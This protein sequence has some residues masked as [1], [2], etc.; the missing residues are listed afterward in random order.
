MI[1]RPPSPP[2]APL[3]PLVLPRPVVLVRPAVDLDL[4]LLTGLED[5]DIAH[6]PIEHIRTQQLQ[7]PALGPQLVVLGAQRVGGPPVELDLALGAGL[8]DGSVERCLGHGQRI[9][10]YHFCSELFGVPKILVLKSCPLHY[11]AARGHRRVVVAKVP[12]QTVS[13][14]MLQGSR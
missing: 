8:P 9:F 4:A 10:F 3:P 7:P 1:G 11:P 5:S 12:D 14:F 13:K 6:I 2:L